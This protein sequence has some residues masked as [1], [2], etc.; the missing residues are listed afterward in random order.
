MQF[1]FAYPPIIIL[2]ARTDQQGRLSMLRLGIDA[3]L[4][5]PFMEE[6]LLINVKNSIRL[7]QNVIEFDKKSTT[8]ELKIL[9]EYA[10]K[11][12]TKITLIKI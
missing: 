10:D 1:L 2:T 8:E 12:N 4:H 6:E 7:Y 5:K 3:Y 9:N 11:F